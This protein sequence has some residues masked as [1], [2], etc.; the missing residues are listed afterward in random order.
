MFANGPNQA[1][2]NLDQI[3]TSFCNRTSH[4]KLFCPTIFLWG[5]L[6]NRIIV[7][8][9]CSREHLTPKVSK[10]S[11]LP[12]NL[13]KIITLKSRLPSSSK[14]LTLQKSMRRLELPLFKM[15]ICQK[16]VLLAGLNTNVYTVLSLANRWPAA[17]VSKSPLIL[18]PSLWRSTT[19]ESFWVA[20]R[21][22]NFLT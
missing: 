10:G 16:W 3:K 5:K 6:W 11:G 2:F 20:S 18:G 4:L 1:W 14:N 13:R 7:S 17:S 15:M 12:G 9:A 8:T 22:I 19:S 21:M